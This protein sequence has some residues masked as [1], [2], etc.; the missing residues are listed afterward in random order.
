MCMC[1]YMHVDCYYEGRGILSRHVYTMQS[2]QCTNLKQVTLSSMKMLVQFKR[3]V[4][5]CFVGHN[6]EV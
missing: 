5:S 4:M 6:T 3:I 1:V 2:T